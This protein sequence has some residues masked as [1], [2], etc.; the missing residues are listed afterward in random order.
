M[1]FNIEINSRAATKGQALLTL[2]DLLGIA[3]A[4]SMALG[5]GTNDLDMIQ[6]AGIGVAMANG[7]PT[8]L[9]AADH[10]TGHCNDAGF[11]K[12]VERFVLNG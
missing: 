5:D 3:P 10:V 8:V 4:D 7:D 9:A 12:A 1:P 2:C 6:N 11:A